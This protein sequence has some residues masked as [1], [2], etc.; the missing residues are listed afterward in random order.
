MLFRITE[1]QRIVFI[2]RNILNLSYKEI[3][4]VLQINENVVKSRLN[5]AK[6]NLQKHVKER[7]Q[8][9]NKVSSCTC[10]KCVGFALEL[11]PELFKVI[12]EQTHRPEYYQTAANY[13]N[14]IKDV[15]TV[16]KKLPLLEYKILPL[17]EYLK[18]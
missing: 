9:Y 13:L 2:F 17:K 5:R 18:K 6:K 7:C 11:T 8:W 10:E 4:E 14:N 12:E 16:F 15:E 1:E 3:S